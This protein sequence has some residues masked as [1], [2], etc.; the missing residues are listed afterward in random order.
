CSSARVSAMDLT[1]FR[2]AA[3]GRL[4][5]VGASVSACTHSASVATPTPTTGLAL[6]VVDSSRATQ[7]LFAV[8][9][10]LIGPLPHQDTI[11]CR[12]STRQAV[13]WVARVRPGRYQLVL[14][15][16]GYAGRTVLVD[17][18]QHQTD[19]V[20]VGLRPL[21]RDLEGPIATSS[22]VPRCGGRTGE[23]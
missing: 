18:A 1:S 13:L 16:P 15:R 7:P 19:T 8:R 21:T 10:R 17:V 22:P 4:L 9:L 3:L 5:A 2:I 12:D 23:Q 6:R 20:T 14:R 11:A